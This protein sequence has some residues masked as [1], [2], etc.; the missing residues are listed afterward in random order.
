MTAKRQSRVASGKSLNLKFL[1]MLNKLKRSKVCKDAS[2]PSKD[3]PRAAEVITVVLSGSSLSSEVPDSTSRAPKDTHGSDVAAGGFSNI[4][5]NPLQEQTFCAKGVKIAPIFLRATQHRKSKHGSDG[6]L[7][8]SAEKLQK[9]VLPPQS[10]GVQQVR[11]QPSHLTERKWSPSALHSCLEDIRTSNPA[12]PVRAVFITL[13]K[14]SNLQDSENALK[15]SSPQNHLKEKRKRENESS[16]CEPKRMRSSHI[17]PEGDAAVG[18]CHI[19]A[20]G[21]QGSTVLTAR[22][23]PGSSKLSRSYRLRQQSG[24]PAGLVINCEPKCE[25]IKDTEYHSQS[26]NTSN[27]LQRDSS[28][29]DVLWTDKYSPQH[30]SE[31]IG[32]SA[33]VT[34]LQ[35][36]L[37]QWKL[38]ADRD[39]KRKLDERKQEENSNDSWDCG[40]FQGEAGTEDDREETLCN[41][42]L[43]T[44]PPGVGKTAAVYACCQELGFKVF[45]V[46]CSS[47]RSGCHILSQLKEATQSHLV[48][49]SGKDPLK[50]TYFNNYSST[51][52]SESLSGKTV[53]PKNVTSTS[54]KRAAQSFGRSRRKLKANPA[55]ITLAN[56][57]TMKAKADH[58]HFGGPSPS[59]KPDCKTSG[60]PSPASDQTVAQNKKTAT[61]LILFEEVDVIFD[62]D[63]GFLSAIKTFMTTTKR[64]VVLTTNDPSFRERF[65]CSLEEIIFKTPSAVSVCSYLQ[66]VA[67]AENVRLELEDVSGLLRLSRGDV[68]RCLLQLQLWVHSGGGRAS[69]RA[70]LTKE[71]IGVQHSDV[72]KKGDDVDSQLP[73]CDTG[74][75]AS[76]LG[77][78]PLTQNQV[79]NLLKCQ[80]WSEIDMMKLLRLLSESWRRGV[81]LLYCNLELLLPIKETSVH[82]LDEGTCSGPHSELATPDPHIQ[83][84][85]GNVS[86]K[87]STTDSKS[88][89]KISRLSRRKYIMQCDITSSS[90]VT[91]APLRTSSSSKRTHSKAACSRDRTEQN[92]AKVESDCLDALTDYFDLMSYLD[93]TMPA[94]APLV[95][96]S[97]TPEAFVWT[98][99]EIKDGLLDEMSEEEEK[100][101]RGWSQ[102]RLLDIQAA[103]EGL[104]FHRYLWRVFEA[105]TEGQ[106]YRQE[107]G[108]TRWGRLVERLMLPASSKSLSFSFQ[109]LCAPRVCQRRYELSRMVLSSKS[110]N[111]LGNRRA[112]SV[113]YIPVLRYICRLQRAQRQKEEP[114]RCLNYL[115]SKHLGLSKSTVHLL[116]EDFSWRKVWNTEEPHVH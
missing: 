54:K 70:D 52:K 2:C 112:V 96:G 10:E 15:I 91:E 98:G 7:H 24:I 50:P 41:T 36:W 83:Q 14:K 22:K 115:S 47:Q 58:L 72:T 53:P 89:R 31:I 1:T 34:K 9:S 19:S 80:F 85:D 29:E 104:G 68:R 111:V 23:Q 75:T 27:I 114:V 25:V 43:I 113:D 97:C 32:N 81:P 46:N 99:V 65:N 86:P 48:E 107:L 26:L 56:Y 39:E 90:S 69:Q 106:K 20:Q 73:Q 51:P 66:L 4:K 77:L 45:E 16:E 62:A 11:S 13:Q 95:P 110:F 17:I 38:R 101:G 100:E 40:D 87:A 59:E 18:H 103:V 92:A 8:Q 78:Q 88:V 102:E 67:L 63:V 49:M 105:W 44:G 55:T 3:Q 116:A 76:M 6:K 37:K 79:L 35:K 28:F 93:A 57:F 71:L 33:S 64:P 61:S 21:V 30:S 12:F 108:D 42:M 74:C 60:S 84:L 82:F 94:A 5:V 109:P